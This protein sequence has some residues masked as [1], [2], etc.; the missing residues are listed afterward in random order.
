MIHYQHKVDMQRAP[1]TK[2]RQLHVGIIGAGFAGLR[3][4]D[5]L[6][7]RFVNTETATASAPHV[8]ILNR[9]QRMQSH[10]PRGAGPPRRTRRPE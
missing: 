3:A 7:Q 8:T 9:L 10:N 1:L 6:L 5:V 2:A 4:A